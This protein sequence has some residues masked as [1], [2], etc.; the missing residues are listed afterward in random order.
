MYC[1]WVFHCNYTDLAGLAWLPFSAVRIS[2]LTFS[3]SLKTCFNRSQMWSESG[4]SFMLTSHEAW[5][6]LASGCC[7]G[8]ILQCT[9]CAEKPADML[10]GTKRHVFTCSQQHMCVPYVYEE[11]VGMQ[12]V[13]RL[14]QHKHHTCEPIG[15]NQC[16]I[17]HRPTWLLSFLL[18]VHV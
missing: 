15:S 5:S 16:L 18:C 2:M 7:F 1:T 11:M 10:H 13:N 6:L 17:L 3:T 12:L 4:R 9:E 8:I 14:S